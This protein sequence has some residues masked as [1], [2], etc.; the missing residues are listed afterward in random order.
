MRRLEEAESLVR[1]LV[2]ERAEAKAAGAST[3][4]IEAKI[5]SVSAVVDNLAPVVGR[6]QTIKYL[7]AEAT[8]VWKNK[9]SEIKELERQLKLVG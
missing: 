8:S 2:T 3:S 6:Q 5:R 4:R 7:W 1:A 9:V